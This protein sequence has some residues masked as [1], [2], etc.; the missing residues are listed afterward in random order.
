MILDVFSSDGIPTHILTLDAIRMY[1]MHLSSNGLMMFHVSNRYLTIAPQIAA[2]VQ[3]LG[4]TAYTKL[5]VPDTRIRP[6]TMASQWVAVPLKQS[7][8]AELLK[9]NWIKVEPGRTRAWTD[10]RSSLL[11][12]IRPISVKIS[13]HA[14]LVK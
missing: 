6:F 3:T 12:A 4:L 8:G 2:S 1:P 10:Q 5:D 9:Q 13:G 7:Q 11:T 14:D